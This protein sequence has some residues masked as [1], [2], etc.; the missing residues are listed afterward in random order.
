VSFLGG[1]LGLFIGSLSNDAKGASTLLPMFVFTFL[2]FSGLFKNL[3]NI[4]DWIGWIQYFTPVKYTFASIINNQILYSPNSRIAELN[5]NTGLWL[6]IGLL[7][8]LCIAYR[9]AA[10]FLLWKFKSKLQ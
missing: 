10:F 4:P 2:V 1:S 7:A 6:S 5:L 9:L 3:A 8:V